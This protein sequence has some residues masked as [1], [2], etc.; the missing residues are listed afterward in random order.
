MFA[1]AKQIVIESPEED[2]DHE[3]IFSAVEGE[4]NILKWQIK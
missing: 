4:R 2:A 3:N 1:P